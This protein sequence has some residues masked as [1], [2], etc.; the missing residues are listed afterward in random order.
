MI[1]T[2]IIPSFYPAVVY[3]G[4]I[5]STLNT[6]KELSKLDSVTVNVSTTNTNMTNR[7]D[8]VPNRYLELEKNLNVKYYNETIVG[9]FSS[10]LFLNIWRDIKVSDV[11]HIQAIFN[12]PI[13]ISLFFVRFFKKPAVLTPRGALGSWVMKR[14]SRFKSIWLWLFIK[15]FVNDIVWHATSQQEK[16]E[17]LNNFPDARVVIIP[18]GIHVNIFKKSSKLNKKKY[19][20]KY[21]GLEI[22]SI[23]KIIISMGRLQEKKGFDILIN[24]FREVLAKFPNSFLLIAGPNEGERDNLERQIFS[25]NLKSKVFLVGNVDGQNK[26]DFFANADLFVLPSHN[27]NFG[28]VYLE[29][30]ASG[31]PIVASTCTPWKDVEKYDC[32]KWV[33]NSVK[34]TSK[35]MIEMLNKNRKLMK[36]NSMSLAAQYD[37]S[38]VALQFEKLFRKVVKLSG[39]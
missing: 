11:V 10:R 26:I 33:K 19:I 39:E 28:N 6:C 36:N 14:G 21:L 4:P 31:T 30:L 34:D 5:F 8:V 16:E 35:A 20:K 13:P 9:K 25:L 18:N 2:I 3:G 29:S 15:P 27:E 7:L 24:S 37:W 38:N 17:I 1:L 22:D 12:T 32:G 23:N